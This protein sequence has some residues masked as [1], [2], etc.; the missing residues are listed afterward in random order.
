MTAAPWSDAV[1]SGQLGLPLRA[2]SWVSLAGGW[3]LEP[4]FWGSQ[5]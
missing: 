2:L 1:S 3:A 5:H 4:L